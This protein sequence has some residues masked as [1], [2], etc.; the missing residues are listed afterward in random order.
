MEFAD[1]GSLWDL[2]G[3]DLKEDEQRDTLDE[4]YCKINFNVFN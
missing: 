3:G 2:L 1:G 4:T